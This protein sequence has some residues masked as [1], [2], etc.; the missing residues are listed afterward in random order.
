MTCA[1]IRKLLNGKVRV[2]KY[3]YE[4]ILDMKS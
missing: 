4:E 3:L 2:W 1:Y